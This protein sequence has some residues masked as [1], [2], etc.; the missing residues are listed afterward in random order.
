MSCSSITIGSSV[1]ECDE[2][3]PSGT[4]ARLILINFVDVV[5]IYTNDDQKI[6]QIVLRSDITGGIALDAPLDAAFSEG[7]VSAGAFEFTGFRNDVKKSDEVVSMDLAKKRF[8][9]AVS[10]V[11]Y[12]VDQLQKTN[13]KNLARGRFLAIVENKGQTEDSIEVLGRECGLEI[14][15]G[16]I[17]DAHETSGFFQI[18]LATPDNGVEYERKL[19]QTLGISYQNGLEIIEDLLGE[20]TPEPVDEFRLLEDSDFRLLQDGAFRLLG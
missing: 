1:E 3:A 2:L 15:G 9:H 11:I 5:R 20:P 10:F 13:I 16:R 17:R 12:E 18:N 6:I 7:G 14:V 4:R 19:P 8:R